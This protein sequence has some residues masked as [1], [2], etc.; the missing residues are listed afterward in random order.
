MVIP[1][2]PFLGKKLFKNYKTLLNFSKISE[3]IIK[4]V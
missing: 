4:D 2:S 1:L 3:N